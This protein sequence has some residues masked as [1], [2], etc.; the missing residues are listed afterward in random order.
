[1]TTWSLLSLGS[2]IVLNLGQSLNQDSKITRQPS[3]YS[4]FPT[5]STFKSSCP[6]NAKDRRMAI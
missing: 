5:V 2:I 1:M 6:K 4:N 3:L